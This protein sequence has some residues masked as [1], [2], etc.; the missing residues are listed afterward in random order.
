MA[1]A[2]LSK[3]GLK[4]VRFLFCTDGIGSKGLRTFIK[5]SYAEM[6]LANKD[7]PLLVRYGKGTE[8][9]MLVR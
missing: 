9:R 4:E 3:N 2:N 5:K 8:A 1:F 7:L 6:K